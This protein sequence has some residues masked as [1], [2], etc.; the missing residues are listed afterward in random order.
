MD[1]SI[2]VG[3]TVIRHTE[4]GEARFQLLGQYGF[5]VLGLAHPDFDC[6]G[7]GNSLDWGPL[8]VDDF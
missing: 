3:P 6:L 2:Q 4:R 1:L 7:R 8:S 5:E